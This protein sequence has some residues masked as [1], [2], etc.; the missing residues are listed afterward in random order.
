MSLI[1]QLVD[2]PWDDERF[3]VVPPGRRVEAGFDERI[4]KAV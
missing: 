4:V 3:L 1:Q 2:G